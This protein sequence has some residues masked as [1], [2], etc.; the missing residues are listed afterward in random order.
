LNSLKD[1]TMKT[2][3]MSLI[4]TL[5]LGFTTPGLSGVLSGAASKAAANAAAKRAAVPPAGF[6]G[7]KP[8]D[9]L[10]SRSKYPESASHIEHAQRL[11]QPSVLT[12][13][14]AGANQRRKE[15]LRHIQR[16]AWS[17][18]NRDRDEYPFAMTREGGSNSSVRYIDRSD[19]RG[20]GSN[21]RHQTQSLPDGA[22]VRVIVSD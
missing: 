12:M 17:A 5:A 1:E 2:S 11:G 9:L 16:K 10:V 22:R 6:A 21:I 18:P 3:C 20:A 15:S 4:V 7:K 14:R 19:N 8:H 13:D